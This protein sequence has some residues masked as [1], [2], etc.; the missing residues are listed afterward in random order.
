MKKEDLIKKIEKQIP[1]VKES[2]EY[3]EREQEGIRR[4]IEVPCKRCLKFC[5]KTYNYVR[6]RILDIIKES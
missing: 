2:E 6:N 5:D 1:I 4:G 3:T